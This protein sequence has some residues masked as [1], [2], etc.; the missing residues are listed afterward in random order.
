MFAG[1]EENV[2]KALAGEFTGFAADF[3]DAERDAQ[4]GIVA[5]KAAIFAVIDALVG[6]IKR[7]EEANDFS[8]ALLGEALGAAAKFFELL[9]CGI[10]EQRWKISE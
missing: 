2:A 3:I 10:G 4:D 1:D 6:E 9:R 5:R 8:E 7:S